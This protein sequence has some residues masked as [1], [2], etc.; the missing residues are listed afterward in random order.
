MVAVH[1]EDPREREMPDLGVVS[2]EDAETGEVV[3]LDTGD[4]AVRSTFRQQS[5]QRA[6][7]L[8]GDLRGEG[9]DTLELLTDAPYLPALQR[10]FKNRKR[11]H[12]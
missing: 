4:P 6:K 10:F 9:V 8:V 3:E 2:L 12:A 11:R 1:I 5:A 7:N